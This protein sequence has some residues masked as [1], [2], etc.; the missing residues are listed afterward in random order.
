MQGYWKNKRMGQWVL[1]VRESWTGL[2]S[3]SLPMGLGG[4][5]Q[6]GYTY[7]K[8]CLSS[9]VPN[10]YRTF[11]KVC[12]TQPEKDTCSQG[13]K[14]QLYSDCHSPSAALGNHQHI[15][16]PRARTASWSCPTDLWNPFP[17]GP[18]WQVRSLFSTWVWTKQ[19]LK[20]DLSKLQLWGPIQPVVYFGI[21][22]RLIW[23]CRW[24][25]VIAFVIGHTDFEPRLCGMLCHWR[26]PCF[27]LAVD[28]KHC[29]QLSLLYFE[30]HEKICGKVLSLL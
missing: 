20:P 17:I 27:S 4:G 21:A 7:K 28:L 22:W 11:I 25:F 1:K 3:L 15:Y 24:P 8:D 30:L 16:T 18:S 29:T 2:W 23:L 5:G 12:S 19:W 10:N 9:T 6:V 14:E 13:S 26:I